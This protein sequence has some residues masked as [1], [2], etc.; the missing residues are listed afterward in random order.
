MDIDE[1]KE[2]AE[3]QTPTQESEAS[4]LKAEIERLKA[5]VDEKDKGFKSLQRELSEREKKLQSVSTQ[6][7]KLQALRDDFKTLAAWVASSAGKTPEE[8]EEAKTTNKDNLLAEFEKREKQR[9]EQQRIQE[10]KQ[11]GD[12]FRQRVEALGLT[13]KDEEYWDIHDLV[14]D[15]KLQRAD[16]KL[17]KLEA[18]KEVPVENKTLEKK[19]SE[20]ERINR[21]V[22]ERLQKAMEAKGLLTSDAGTPSS[23]A[24][25]RHKANQKY[26][27]GEISRSEYEKFLK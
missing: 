19:E 9:Q 27:A 6:E 21:L 2:T 12:E 10:L 14:I 18:K 20:D 5:Q 16:V 7:E 24:M 8:Y 25:D 15:G 26:I 22:E 3:Q 1:K 4:Q 13:D 23:G 17:K 11:K